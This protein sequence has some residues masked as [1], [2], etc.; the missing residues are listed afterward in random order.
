MRS[1]GKRERCERRRF[2][3][4]LKERGVELWFEGE[5][6]RYR[7][8]KGALTDEQR[9]ELSLR[10]AEILAQLRAD[11]AGQEKTFPLSFSQRSMWFVHQQAPESWAYH[12]VTA[13]RIESDVNVTA[14]RQALQSL[15]DRHAVLRT[16]YDFVDGALSQR[17]AGIGTATFDIHAVP[18]LTDDE[19]RVLVERDYRRPFDL[20]SG[21]VFR[22][23]LY[24]SA[25][26]DHVLLL[27]VHHI[28]IDAWS[29]LLLIDEL[30][31]LYVEATGGAPA[32]LPRP[33]L[34]YTDYASW[35]E[36]TLAGPEGDR[37]W[38][39]WREKLAPPRQLL[40]LATN[41]PR[42]AVQT[43]RGATLPIQFDVGLTQK[44]KDLARYEGT[45]AF[46]VL[47][48][49]FQ[50]F[51]FRHSGVEDVIVGTPT[52][53]RS[54]AEFM[55]VVGDFVN[56]VP[57]RGRLSAI[58]TFR[59]LVAQLRQTVIEALDAQE[60]P[61][62]LLVQRLQPERGSGH[63]PLFNTFF[64]LLRFEQ[65]KNLEAIAAGDGCGDAV[66]FGSL[67]LRA[68]PINQQEGQFDLAV[69]LGERGDAFCGAFAYSTDLFEE[70]TVQAYV[71][72]YLALV[73]SLVEEPAAP[74]GDFSKT[75]P[76]GDND[77]FVFI[78]ELRNRDIRIL[79]DG[80][81]MRVNAPKGSLD[82]G[83]KKTIAARRN[84]I[85]AALKSAAVPAEKKCGAEVIRQ[86]SRNGSLPVSSAQQR[87]WFME[88][89]QPG[90]SEY[91][92]GGPVR[93]HGLLDIETMRQAVNDLVIRHRVLFVFASARVTAARES[94][95]WKRR[96]CHSK[97]LTYR[98][99][100]KSRAKGLLLGWQMHCSAVPLI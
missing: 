74:L 65:A 81:Q 43:F 4:V 42:P 6:L 83:L 32:A 63:S 64:S 84:E 59:D 36:R 56:S 98:R 31:K 26:A 73:K 41:F 10:R 89:M 87:F 68:Y 90:R 86:I 66:E 54:K 9:A 85:V 88:Q 97:S 29:L 38:S 27:N 62:P 77:V 23:S 49:S 50:V 45:T 52:F 11:A 13:A 71:A 19:L 94:N 70:T 79:L 25:R 18:G 78:E 15:V 12:V 51:L 14:M 30:L 5:R 37:L 96:R 76:S 24:T 57:L 61:L 47:L 44:I 16:S 1:T 22:A 93:Y 80:E 21:Q 91:N 53:A 67:Q 39:Y 100:P 7:A 34:Q 95:F 33:E 69:R 99:H 46:V 48:A 3:N 8:P 75:V 60:F 58:M 40:D 72:D 20:R 92:T 82:D 28:A 55:R 17:V 35:Q 2:L